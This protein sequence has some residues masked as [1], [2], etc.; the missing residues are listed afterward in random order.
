MIYPTK[1][2]CFCAYLIITIRQPFDYY[3][4]LAGYLGHAAW[5]RDTPNGFPLIS[6]FSSGG[7]EWADINS[8][9]EIPLAVPS[10]NHA[11]FFHN[12]VNAK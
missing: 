1:I 10:Q 3:D 6:T 12:T 11:P 4:I 8:E 7:Y 5:F 9:H 2:V